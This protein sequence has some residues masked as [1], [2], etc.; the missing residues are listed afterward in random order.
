[1]SST[2]RVYN[3][4][5]EIMNYDQLLHYFKKHN[6]PEEEI[7]RYFFNEVW[8]ATCRNGGFATPIEVLMER[9][10]A[11]AVPILIDMLNDKLTYQTFAV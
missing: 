5:G 9:P 1:M 10:E 7:I 2:V 6:F 3:C 4:K 8:S 11:I